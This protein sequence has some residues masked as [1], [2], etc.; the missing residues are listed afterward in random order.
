VYH[1]I[2]FSRGDEYPLPPIR[3]VLEASAKQPQRLSRNK[4]IP[5][6]RFHYRVI[7]GALCVKAAS[8]RSFLL[9]NSAER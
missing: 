4:I 7:A 6:I 3:I 9:D 2:G 8:E 1:T 5:N